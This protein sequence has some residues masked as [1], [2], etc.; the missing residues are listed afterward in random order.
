M[1][2]LRTLTWSLERSGTD[3]TKP[4]Y[5][6]E[7]DAGVGRVGILRRSFDCPLSSLLHTL[8]IAL[9]VPCST[10]LPYAAL[11]Y[12]AKGREP[13]PSAAVEVAEERFLERRLTHAGVGEI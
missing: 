1:I 2:C 8:M 12:R 11:D 5:D 4:L 3:E 10:S 9:G 7:T 13:A 6:R